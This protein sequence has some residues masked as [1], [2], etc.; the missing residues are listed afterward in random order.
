[1]P[2]KMP[3]DAKRMIYGGFKVIVDGHESPGSGSGRSFHA[4]EQD[5]HH[6]WRRWRH[7]RRRSARLRAR[8]RQSLPGRPHLEQA[9][10]GRRR[11]IEMR[12]ARSRSPRSTPSMKKPSRRMPI[13]SRPRPAASTS[14]STRSGCSMSRA[15][16]SPISRSTTMPFR[17]S[18]MPRR[19]SSPPRRWPGIW[20]S[21][22]RA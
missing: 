22:N 21:A 10:E 1:M 20:R 19:I 2:K 5:R 11:H 6:L 4:R 14:P 18:P 17:S 8:R 9:G 13:W 16:L 15:R 3:F 12:A 7:W